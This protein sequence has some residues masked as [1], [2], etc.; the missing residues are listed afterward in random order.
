MELTTF[1]TGIYLLWVNG[2]EEMVVV[3][4][5]Q[6]GCWDKFCVY[7]DDPGAIATCQEVLCQLPGVFAPEWEEESDRQVVED[8]FAELADIF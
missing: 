3:G 5:T 6:P 7:G 8:G 4:F 2:I 1:A